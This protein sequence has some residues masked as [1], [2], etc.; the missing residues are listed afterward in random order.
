MPLSFSNTFLSFFLPGSWS[1]TS[2]A[3]LN[4]TVKHIL[5]AK[6]VSYMRKPGANVICDIETGLKYNQK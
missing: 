1:L 2:H 3:H 6:H 4:L 5:S